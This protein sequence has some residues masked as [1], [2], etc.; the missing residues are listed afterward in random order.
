MTKEVLRQE[1]YEYIR[2]MEVVDCHEHLIPEEDALAENVDVSLLF[3][4]YTGGDFAA[5]GMTKEES[6]AFFGKTASLEQKWKI[7]SRIYPYV[8]D[9]GYM[10]SSRLVIAHD[11]GIEELNWESFQL[12][13]KRVKARRKPGYYKETF[14]DCK[15]KYALNNV[16]SEIFPPGFY[17]CESTDI[18]KTVVRVP[19]AP[20]GKDFMRE[21]NFYY[22]AKSV[23]DLNDK[24]AEFVA[25][26]LQ[27]G[28]R[29]IKIM[30][31]YPYERVKEPAACEEMLR[32][33]QDEKAWST[34]LYWYV[35]DRILEEAAKANL[36]ACV[37]TGY[38]GDF[39]NQNPEKYISLIDRHR[40]NRFDVFH[41]GYPYVKSALLLA[42]TRPNVY[43][44]LCWTFNISQQ[45]G[46]EGLNQIIDLIPMNKVIG[47]GGD[48]HCIERVYGAR[49]MM[50]Q[51]MSRALADKVADGILSLERAK[52]WA[53]AML[54]DNPIS[55]YGPQSY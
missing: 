40:K 14:Q 33:L 45:L 39:R 46:Y 4:L 6:D 51:T 32:L 18:L 20:F 42:K 17:F 27:I 16:D 3:W 54:W 11:Y 1:M 24:A 12:L 13:D 23:Q 31:D 21:G 36:P 38:W 5:A 10:K 52:T 50:N 26:V 28:G 43:I 15:I 8:E 9:T 25:K 44:N 2:N 55:L 49:E 30:N 41:L 22:G 53:R 47:Y 7:F 48:Y 19:L 29:G 37:H 35:L 34:K